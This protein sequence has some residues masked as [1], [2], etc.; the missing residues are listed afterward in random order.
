LAWI[1]AE[2]PALSAAT[3]RAIVPGIQQV[4]YQPSY[5]VARTWPRPAPRKVEPVP[6]P[7]GR[8]AFEIVDSAI[9]TPPSADNRLPALKTSVI[10]S[11]AL[12]DRALQ[13]NFEIGLRAAAPLQS[14]QFLLGVSD[15]GQIRYSFLH[16]PS[17]NQA[18]DDAAAL[19]LTKLSFAPGPA[20]ITWGF[21]TIAWG[22]DIYSPSSFTQPER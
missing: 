3:A 11:E 13:G 7:A 1:V 6:L 2:D 9:T 16:S 5:A 15:T 20:P 4:P 21:V 12:A 19:G 14:A 8:S 10:V 18:I 17:G 22:D